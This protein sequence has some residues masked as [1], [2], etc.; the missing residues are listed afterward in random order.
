LRAAGP[1][2]IDGEQNPCIFVAHLYMYM[3]WILDTCAHACRRISSCDSSL[4]T[5]AVTPCEGD[6]RGCGR[7]EYRASMKA[8]EAKAEGIHP[9]LIKNKVFLQGWDS[10]KFGLTEQVG[11]CLVPV[12]APLL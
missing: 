8:A 2:A 6:G 9:M 7:K 4:H 12:D 10:E 3:S 5:T 1:P 11:A